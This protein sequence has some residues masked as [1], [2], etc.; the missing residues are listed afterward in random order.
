MRGEEGDRNG[1]PPGKGSAAPGG[2][3][4]AREADV[5]AR[6]L[7]LLSG[8]L[9]LEVE[10]ETDLLES[11]VLDSLVFVELVVRLEEVFGVAIPVEE[12]ELDDF[13]SA[14]SIARTLARRIQE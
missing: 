11:G 9:E 13:R 10:P 4:A 8:E 12:L 14:R 2:P 6:L 3:A 5:E 1:S 7:R